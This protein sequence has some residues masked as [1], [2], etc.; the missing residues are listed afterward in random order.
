MDYRRIRN[1]YVTEPRPAAWR[2]GSDGGFR[3]IPAAKKAKESPEDK[4]VKDWLGKA[5]KLEVGKNGQFLSDVARSL[6]KSSFEEGGTD[7]TREM[8]DLLQT[9]A[10]EAFGEGWNRPMRRKPE[11]D[12]ERKEIVSGIMKEAQKLLPKPQPRS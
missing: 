1:D 6:A 4:R 9:A 3:V 10:D 5:D 7:H 8:L 12:G 11:V 2:A